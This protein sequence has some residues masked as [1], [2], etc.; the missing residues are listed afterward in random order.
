M[1]FEHISTR[2]QKILDNIRIEYADT[3]FGLDWDNLLHGRCPLCSCKLHQV[4]PLDY[5][6][7]ICKSVK[8]KKRFV[9]K[10]ETYQQLCKEILAKEIKSKV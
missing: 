5:G 8:H 6:P 10:N 1:Q 4:R 2:F 3:L 9:I 7:W